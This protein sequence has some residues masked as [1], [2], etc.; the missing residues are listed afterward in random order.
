MAGEPNWREWA[1]W[2]AT[3]LRLV[4]RFG[5]SREDR[6]AAQRAVDEFEA[7]AGGY[8]LRRWRGKPKDEPGAHELQRWRDMPRSD[9]S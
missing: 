8:E 7:E 4:L 3:Q 9:P 2:L 1:L 6:D 5:A